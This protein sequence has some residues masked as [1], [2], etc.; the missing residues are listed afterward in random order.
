MRRHLLGDVIYLHASTHFRSPLPQINILLTEQDISPLLA[1][2]NPTSYTEEDCRPL[3]EGAV[4]Q[5]ITLTVGLAACSLKTH[6][7]RLI[8]NY[9]G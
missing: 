7:R 4:V 3:S 6:F 5:I 2:G 1:V 9:V 8:G